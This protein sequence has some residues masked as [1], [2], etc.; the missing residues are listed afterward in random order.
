MM[1]GLLPGYKKCFFCGPATGGL[2]LELHYA[3]DRAMCDFTAGDRF[4]GY[5]GMLHGGIV[6]GILD[7]VMWWT[8]FTRTR[9]M[10]ATSKIEVEFKRPVECGRMYRASGSFL[11]NTGRICYL[12]GV[13]ENEHGKICARGAA[14]FREFRFTLEELARQLDF[15]GVSPEIRALFQPPVP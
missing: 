1:D 5:D 9:R 12:S 15:R 13:I 2:G 11:R 7:E 14:S 6:T 10:Y 4:Q 3:D 8:I